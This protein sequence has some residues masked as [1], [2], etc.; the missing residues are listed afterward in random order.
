MTVRDSDSRNSDLLRFGPVVVVVICKSDGILKCLIACSAF[1]KPLL[2]RLNL[3][4]YRLEKAAPLRPEEQE[5]N[6][7]Q[8]IGIWSDTVKSEVIVL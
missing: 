1:G 2:R 3:S 5:P 7:A 8:I 6:D 4:R